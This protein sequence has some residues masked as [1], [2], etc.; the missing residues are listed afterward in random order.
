MWEMSD[1]ENKLSFK[2]KS[3]SSNDVLESIHIDQ[4]GP[5]KVQS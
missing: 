5:I 1:W 4:Y 2:S 3:Y